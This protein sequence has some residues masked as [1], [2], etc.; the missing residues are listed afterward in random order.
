MRGACLPPV[1]LS[2]KSE[3][4]SLMPAADCHQL[5]PR[6]GSCFLHW[7]LGAWHLPERRSAVGGAGSHGSGLPLQS[8]LCGRWETG[9]HSGD[10]AAKPAKAKQR[11]RGQIPAACGVLCSAGAQQFS[12][13]TRLQGSE[14][15]AVLTGPRV[16]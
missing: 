9:K 3:Q 15:T 1:T 12:F 4:P 5:A 16:S 2:E 11:P 6:A 10:R 14:N 13:L 8:P 7:A